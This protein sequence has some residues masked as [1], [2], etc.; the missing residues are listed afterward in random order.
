MNR[1][2]KIKDFR[3]SCCR[4]FRYCDDCPFQESPYNIVCGYNDDIPFEQLIEY[5]ISVKEKELE[6]LKE[7]KQLLVQ[8][9]EDE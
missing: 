6:I 3:K 5:M 2:N 7:C 8:E 1:E 4:N 9:I